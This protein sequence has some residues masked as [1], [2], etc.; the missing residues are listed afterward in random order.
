MVVLVPS[1]AQAQSASSL[2]EKGKCWTSEDVFHK[3]HSSAD[4]QALQQEP[5]EEQ[6]EPPQEQQEPPQ[7]QQEPLQEQQELLQEQ[8]EPLQEQ[9]EP[10]QQ[11]KQQEQQTWPT[12]ARR[13]SGMVWPQLRLWGVGWSV[14]P[15]L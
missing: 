5:L 9:Q 10:Q 1:D 7:E 12:K 15:V 2:A 8:Q 3:R 6:Q 14:P 4:K 11:A 13:Y